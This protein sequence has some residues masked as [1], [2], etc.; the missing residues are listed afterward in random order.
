MPQIDP[1][2]CLVCSN[3]QPGC[4]LITTN[5]PGCGLSTSDVVG[6]YLQVETDAK[7]QAESWNSSC[8]IDEQNSMRCM[9]RSRVQPQ[10]QLNLS[11][12]LAPT[13][14]SIT[15]QRLGKLLWLVGSFARRFIVD[16]T[17]Q[18]PFWGPQ[19]QRGI[20]VLRLASGQRALAA[21]FGWKRPRG[22]AC[23][24]LDQQRTAAPHQAPAS[25]APGPKD[26]LPQVG[27]QGN[28]MSLL[29]AAPL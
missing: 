2:I 10:P 28:V 17:T 23:A 12:D 18:A 20:Q 9:L 6:H 29:Q 5:K 7:N 16:L 24:A 27:H 13:E 25:P 26:V 22:G 11:W 19:L 1:N 21:R 4:I 15:R 14:F 8:I 3:Q